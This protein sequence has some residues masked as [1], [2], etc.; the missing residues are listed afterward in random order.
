MMTAALR[1][2]HSFSQ[3]FLLVLMAGDTTSVQADLYFMGKLIK[4]GGRKMQ[5]DVI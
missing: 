3:P 5:N 2:E 4:H 1:N